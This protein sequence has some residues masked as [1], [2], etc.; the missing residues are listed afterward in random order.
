MYCSSAYIE[1]FLN[2]VSEAALLITDS[3][4]V[5][6]IDDGSPDD[7]LEIAKRL[8]EGVDELKIV[9]LSKNH[10]HHRAMMVGLEQACGNYVFLTDIDLEESP[11]NLS[12]FWETHEKNPEVDVIYGLQPEKDTPFIRKQLSNAFYSF[13]NSLSSV[14]ISNRELVSRLM[15]RNFVNNLLRYGEHSIFLPAL[16]TD[17]GFNQLSIPV[18]KSFDGNST[19]S[20][21][22]RI[23]L[24][25]DAL[26]SFS[27]K[28]LVYVFYC[29][30]SISML[31]MLVICY[32]VFKKLFMGAPLLGWTSLIATI[33]FMGGLILFSLGIIGIYISKIYLEVKSR[34]TAIIKAIHTRSNNGFT[35]AK[36]N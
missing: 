23:T 10:G 13:F 27:A 19:Y 4:E 2:R 36:K 12:I 15:N 17:A 24:A 14:K 20:L 33:F 31:A 16:W 18:S 7:S 6:L 25:V 8:G 9:E 3:Y 1:E 11:E 30:L 5:I 21:A 34:P 26:T 35:N 28:P 32:L 29:G 22:K